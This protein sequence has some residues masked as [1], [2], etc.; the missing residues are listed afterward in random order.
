MILLFKRPVNMKNFLFLFLLIIC[1]AC[2][3]SA[4]LSVQTSY[5]TRESLASYYVETPDPLLI[6]PPIEQRLIVTW[7]VPPYYL[8]QYDDLHLSIRIRFKNREEESLSILLTNPCGSY[9]Y[10]LADARYFET[11]GLLTYKVDLVGGGNILE[12]WRHQLWHELILV[13]EDASSQESQ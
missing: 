4:H 1:A 2:S 12:E 8:K 6:N 13:G 7:S 11:K 3:K 10:S 5:F 9:I